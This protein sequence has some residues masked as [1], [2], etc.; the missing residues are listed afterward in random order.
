MFWLRANL[1]FIS[2]CLSGIH[3]LRVGIEDGEDG[4]LYS[5]MKRVS[6]F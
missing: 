5:L 6:R 4:G 2:V 3:L 1:S